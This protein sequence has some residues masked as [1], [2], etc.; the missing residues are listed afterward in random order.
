VRQ[1]DNRSRD[2]VVRAV[3]A[4]DSVAGDSSSGG[5]VLMRLPRLRCCPWRVRHRSDRRAAGDL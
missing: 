1:T 4:M 3:S 5:V 2:V